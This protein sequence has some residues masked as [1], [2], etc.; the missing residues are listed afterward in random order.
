M[1]EAADTQ[2]TPAAIAARLRKAR[3]RL[4]V[5]P[6]VLGATGHGEQVRSIREAIEAV[7]VAIAASERLSS[8]RSPDVSDT[9]A[10]GTAAGPYETSR[11]G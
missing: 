6:E 4:V 3:A 5:A 1:N 2:L 9:V 8:T 7:E 11:G 10:C